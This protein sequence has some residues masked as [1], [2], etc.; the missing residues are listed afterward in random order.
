MA[1]VSKRADRDRVAASDLGARELEIVRNAFGAS[2]AAPMA[3]A[4]T[5]Y[6]TD[7]D[8]LP[9]GTAGRPLVV[10]HVPY[11]LVSEPHDVV[12]SPVN[13]RESM[14]DVP[15]IWMSPRTQTAQGIEVT[16]GKSIKVTLMACRALVRVSVLSS[17]GTHPID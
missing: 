4:A 9:G 16:V 15:P 1:R 10:D 2:A 14:V 3:L 11:L 12:S 17:V 8:P 7:P 13:G 6:V 5:P